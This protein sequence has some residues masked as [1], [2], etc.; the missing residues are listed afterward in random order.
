MRTVKCLFCLSAC[1]L[2]LS[3]PAFA[4]TG[5]E[6]LRQCSG[7]GG[8]AERKQCESYIDGVISGVDTF[9][10]SVRLLNP[11]STSYPRLFCVPRFTGPKDL[12]AATVKYLERHADTRHYDASSEVL[13]ALQQA[14][15]CK[16]G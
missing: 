16:G 2:A 11:G 5:D 9:T 14:Y 12:V 10:I 13:L 1:A 7:V 4:L 15:P 8:S 6:L 3:M